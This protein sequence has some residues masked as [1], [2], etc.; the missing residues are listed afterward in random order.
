MTV[1]SFVAMTPRMPFAGMVIATV[2]YD[3]GGQCS[4]LALSQATA[5]TLADLNRALEYARAMNLCSWYGDHISV[6]PRLMA[7]SKVAAPE[8]LLDGKRKSRGA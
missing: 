2:V 1:S 3:F 8:L 6:H 4:M 7:P 5:V